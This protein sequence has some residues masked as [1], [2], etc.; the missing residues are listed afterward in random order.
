MND[1]SRVKRRDTSP[2]N[3]ED[4][5]MRRRQELIDKIINRKMAKPNEGPGDRVHDQ[6]LSNNY[7]TPDK[8]DGYDYQPG[9]GAHEG[10]PARNIRVYNSV[11]HEKSANAGKMYGN[12]DASI[13]EENEYNDNGEDGPALDQ[14]SNQFR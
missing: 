10:H 2:L 6:A 1:D 3:D 14:Q 12:N 8:V 7:A 9:A 13:Q 5:A 11:K 4:Q